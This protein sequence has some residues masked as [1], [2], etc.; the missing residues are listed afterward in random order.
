MKNEKAVKIELET[1]MRVVLSDGYISESEE[2]IFIS[3]PDQRAETLKQIE[4]DDQ[5]PPLG[6][7]SLG[8]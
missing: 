7:V 8:F 2:A 6:A 4:K 1:P 3:F 5:G